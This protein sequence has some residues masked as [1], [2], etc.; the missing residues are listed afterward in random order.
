MWQIDSN[1]FSTR[2][3]SSA[4]WNNIEVWS[5]IS[6]TNRLRIRPWDGAPGS[7][8]SMRRC[9]NRAKTHFF[10]CIINLEPISSSIHDLWSLISWN[11]L[12]S[13][14]S[15]CSPHSDSVPWSSRRACT[16]GP[17]WSWMQWWSTLFSSLFQPLRLHYLSVRISFRN[18][19]RYH[20]WRFQTQEWYLMILSS[21]LSR[22][23]SIL[24][25]ISRAFKE[26]ALWRW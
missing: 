7:G 13:G 14:I 1:V 3:I 23:L 15:S 24:L 2:N 25:Y 6:A 16:F 17:W 4:E 22:N 8:D 11:T 26:T 5:V 20:V 18:A 12:T 21:T 10:R 19:D 9:S